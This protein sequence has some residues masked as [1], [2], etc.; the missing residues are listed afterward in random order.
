MATLSS[1]SIDAQYKAWHQLVEKGIVMKQEIRPIIARSWERSLNLVDP[2]NQRQY[3]L[4]ETILHQKRSDNSLLLS[5]AR[6]VMEMICKLPGQK[7]VMLCDNEGYIL[8][9]VGNSDYYVPDLGL[10]LSEDSIGTNAIG[11]AL[12]EKSPMVIR[13]C[14][15][16]CSRYQK[17]NCAAVPLKDSN[18]NILGIIDVT[19][20]ITESPDQMLQI[21]Y[22]AAMAIEKDIAA[23][24]YQKLTVD[25]EQNF[26]SSLDNLDEGI[27]IVNKYGVILDA[28]VKCI[29]ILGLK[30]RASIKGRS[31]FSFI[32]GE[33]DKK[34]FL[35]DYKNSNISNLSLTAKSGILKCGITKKATLAGTENIMIMFSPGKYSYNIGTVG[36]SLRRQSTCNFDN[37][38][39]ESALLAT[40]KKMAQKAAHVNSSILIEGE[41]GT[42][43]ELFAQAIHQESGR[44]GKFVPI[45][46]GAI[47]QELL[48]S[49]LFGYEDGA[50]T[51]ARKGG[52]P[53]K[54]EIADG[55]TV[56]LDEIGEMPL[57]MQVSLLRFLQNKTVTRLGGR[58]PIHV[59]V[60]IIAATN[61]VLKNEVKNG[62]FREDLYYRLNVINIKLPPL[63]KRKEDIPLL[64]RYLADN[65]LKKYNRPAVEISNQVL[66]L[67]QQYDWPGNVRELANVVEN[68]IVFTEGN[69]VNIDSLP[70]WLVNLNND[71]ELDPPVGKIRE[72]ER[73]LIV[74][75]LKK[76]DGNI[77]RS[78]AELGIARNT[79][80]RKMLHMGI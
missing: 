16:Y 30:N 38:I 54:F 35:S 53:G 6:P 77:T 46:C 45:N 58:N 49:E 72:Y 21:L 26:Q 80:Y 56:F 52:A 37:L 24:T 57:N 5:S 28:N 18:G 66:D 36:K 39:G 31:L 65:I 32:S 7:F 62:N 47:N 3:A 13:G 33:V 70:E 20:P 69:V 55:G 50:F 41:S 2:I 25:T 42:G 9:S 1:T 78:A 19:G 29:N 73:T 27:F 4:N 15:H 75:T 12:V 23:K 14:E 10:Q 79:L 22:I 59:N 67:L 71:T 48:Q 34:S 17:Y 51:G 61:R 11:T 68:A 44:K 43:K 63:R 64:T 74:N 76:Y 40:A 8:D 60:R